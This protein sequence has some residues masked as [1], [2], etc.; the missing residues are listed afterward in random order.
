M[1]ETGWLPQVLHPPEQRE[2]GGA[3]GWSVYSVN[4]RYPRSLFLSK[5]K[6]KVREDILYMCTLP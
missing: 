3:G 1:E 4:G 6:G 2:S 5:K